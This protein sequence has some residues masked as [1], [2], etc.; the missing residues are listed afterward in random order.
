[1]A[2]KKLIETRRETPI[3]FEQIR[4][5]T[6]DCKMIDLDD[7]QDHVTDAELFDKTNATCIL[8]TVHDPAVDRVI[9]H[10]ISIVRVGA[11]RKYYYFL[12]SLGNSLDELHERLHTKHEGFFRWT[13]QKGS[14]VKSYPK[15]LQKSA[16]HVQ[17]CG[18]WSAARCK[19][20]KLTP[21]QF[22]NFWK[23]AGMPPDVAISMA[24]FLTLL[25]TD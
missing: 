6:P 5:I 9:R 10:W 23:G 20:K 7:L 17:D 11:K 4:L 8:C 12:D 22:Y 2:L 18:I 25:G 1:M 19:M 16:L 21:K 15:R 3:S 13:Q 14:M 24:G